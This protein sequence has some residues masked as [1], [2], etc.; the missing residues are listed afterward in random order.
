LHYPATV[1]LAALLVHA[2]FIEQFQVTTASMEPVFE[3][4]QRVWVD[5]LTYALRPPR[6]FELI[7]FQGPDARPYVKRVIG[8]PGESVQL[9]GGRLNV[10]GVV[11][12]APVEYVCHG[13]HGVHT[14]CRLAE[15]EFFVLG[16]NSRVS[17]DSRCW[18][19]PGVKFEQIIG[20]PIAGRQSAPP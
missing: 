12:P 19:E 15:G 14:A 3:P 17:D 1:L 2:F 16:D 11:L 10:D 8:L 4:G 9:V 18:P 7:V 20:R 6:R 13:R 5:K